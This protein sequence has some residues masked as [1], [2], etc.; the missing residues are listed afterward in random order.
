MRLMEEKMKKMDEEMVDLR[1][2]ESTMREKLQKEN[3]R[4]REEL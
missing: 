4:L 3:Q 1:L 2:R